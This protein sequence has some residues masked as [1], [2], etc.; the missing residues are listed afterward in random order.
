MALST[1]HNTLCLHVRVVP[2]GATSLDK[3]KK[4]IEKDPALERRFQQVHGPA[5]G[6]TSGRLSYSVAASQ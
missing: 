4:F 2:A 1:L 3:Y 5:N 6:R